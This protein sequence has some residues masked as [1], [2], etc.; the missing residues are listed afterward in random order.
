MAPYFN[1]F[2]NILFVRL[3]NGV[4]GFYSVVGVVGGRLQGGVHLEGGSNSPFSPYLT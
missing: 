2:S 4:Q 1:Y 3:D